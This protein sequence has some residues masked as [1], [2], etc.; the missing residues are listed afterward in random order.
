MALAAQA[1]GL[2]PNMQNHLLLPLP[3]EVDKSGRRDGIQYLVLHS[4]KVEEYKG[5]QPLNKDNLRTRCLGRLLQ[6]SNSSGRLSDITTSG[7]SAKI[8]HTQ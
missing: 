1:I 2:P 3:H 6:T 8:I 4:I 7:R 5:A